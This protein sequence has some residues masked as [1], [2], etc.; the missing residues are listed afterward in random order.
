[1]LACIFSII[2]VHRPAKKHHFQIHTGNWCISSEDTGLTLECGPNSAGVD[3][4]LHG[5]PLCQF[6]FL[7]FFPYSEIPVKALSSYC[8]CLPA[9]KPGPTLVVF[10]VS[11]GQIPSQRKTAHCPQFIFF[12]PAR[13]QQHCKHE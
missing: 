4:S 10:P 6:I 11:L 8:S 9:R 12:K 2:A 3:L 7:L 5:A 13:A 1:M